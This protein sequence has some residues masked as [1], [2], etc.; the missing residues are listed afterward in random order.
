M[1]TEEKNGK[2]TNT[3][4]VLHSAAAYDLLVWLLTFGRERPFRDAM[5]RLAHLKMG[6]SVLDVGCGTGTLAIAA[7][8]Q[9]GTT[10][11]VS[12]IDA[13][14]EMIARAE[15]KARKAGV[16]VAFKTGFAQ[17]LP[18]T[19][20]QFDVVLTTVMLH[21]LPRKARQELA[22]EMRRVLKPGGRVLAIDF[23]ETARKRKSIL[24][25]FHRRHGH[26]ELKDIIGLLKEAGLNVIESGPV[27]M[28]DLQFAL[29]TA[30]CCA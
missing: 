1:D 22:A 12:G 4:L 14:P 19:D 10:G 26:V 21:H 17:S 24:D 29:A 9:V 13:A 2:P 28:R 16:E 27:G 20:A 18:F 3:G 6:E 30:P 15:K 23:A 11:A 5:L 25:H 8:R 7:K